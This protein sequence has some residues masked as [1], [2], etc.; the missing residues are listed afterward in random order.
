MTHRE[1]DAG[2][3]VIEMTAGEYRDFLDSEARSRLGLSL[4]EFMEQY[5]AGQLDDSDP[6]VP[7]LAMWTGMGQNGHRLPA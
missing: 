2:T 4:H 5:A 1:T 7:L 3:P 6:D